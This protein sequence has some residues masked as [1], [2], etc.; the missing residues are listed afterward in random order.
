MGTSRC[1]IDTYQTNGKYQSVY[2]HQRRAGKVLFSFSFRFKPST[3]CLWN[4]AIILEPSAEIISAGPLPP[5]FHSTVQYQCQLVHASFAQEG[6]PLHFPQSGHSLSSSELSFIFM[7]SRWK[8]MGYF[9]NFSLCSPS[10]A[11]QQLQWRETKCQL[12]PT[13]FER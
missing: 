1:L 7:A 11:L 5:K 8:N 12:S 13:V 4:K 2:F 6:F 9:I 10:P 3:Q